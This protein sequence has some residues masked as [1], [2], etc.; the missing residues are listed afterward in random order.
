MDGLYRFNQR[1]IESEIRNKMERLERG[2]IMFITKKRF[3]EEIEKAVMQ[4]TREV[5]DRFYMNDRL[6][7]MERH[8]YKQMEELTERIDRMGYPDSRPVPGCE[9]VVAKPVR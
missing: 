5:E 6:D 4:A 9:E 2:M 7:R 8:F 1:R 3:D